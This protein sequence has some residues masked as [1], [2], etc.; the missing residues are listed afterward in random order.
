MKERLFTFL[1]TNLGDVGKLIHCKLGE[2]YFGL[3]ELDLLLEVMKITKVT[4]TQ[5]KDLMTDFKT[6]L[7]PD[8]IWAKLG[9]PLVVN[10]HIRLTLKVHL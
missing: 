4:V 6:D 5:Q 10:I 3:T 8:L 2:R 7:K 9:E 1:D